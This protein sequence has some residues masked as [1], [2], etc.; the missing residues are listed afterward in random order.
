MKNLVV[1]FSITL[2]SMT[3]IGQDSIQKE[4]N[5]MLYFVK[6]ELQLENY[7]NATMY[8]LKGEKICGDYDSKRYGN[9]A[10]VIMNTIAIA[11]TT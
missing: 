5:R 11:S 9:V 3:S 1:L 2:I 7:A 10:Q 8:Y 4:C 6:Q